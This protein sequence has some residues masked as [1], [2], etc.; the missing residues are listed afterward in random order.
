MRRIAMMHAP[1]LA[2]ASRLFDFVNASAIIRLKDNAFGVSQRERM[3][4]ERPSQM[5]VRRKMMECFFRRD[6]ERQ[7]FY[8][9][10]D[11]FHDGH[12][13]P[14]PIFCFQ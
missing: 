11:I 3:T 14:L 10:F 5:N 9:R 12:V 2:F 13:P 8:N 4:G 7:F 1:P 6:I